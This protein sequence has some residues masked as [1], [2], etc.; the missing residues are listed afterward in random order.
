MQF[1]RDPGRNV[2]GAHQPTPFE[3]QIKHETVLDMYTISRKD[4]VETDRIPLVLPVL[5]CGIHGF[6]SLLLVSLMLSEA[7]TVVKQ[8]L[9]PHTS[10]V[11]RAHAP[12]QPARLFPALATRCAD[13]QVRRTWEEDRSLSDRKADLAA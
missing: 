3:G 9:L 8:V 10:H 5:H 11:F 4:T 2:N 1:Y 12:E 7:E 13:Q 6:H